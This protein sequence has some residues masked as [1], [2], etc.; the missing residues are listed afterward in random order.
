MTEILKICALASAYGRQVLPHGHSLAAAWNLIA[1]QPPGVCPMLEFLCN[2]QPLAQH[3]HVTYVEPVNGTLQ[4]PEAP[5][6]GIVLD[7]AKIEARSEL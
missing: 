6:L 3:F 5:G 2:Y 1:A 4:P 7:E